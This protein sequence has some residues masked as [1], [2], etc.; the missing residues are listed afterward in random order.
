VTCN[1]DAIG[2]RLKL[3]AGGRDQHLVLNGG[4][5][6]GNLPLEQ[7]FGLGRARKAERLEVWWPGGERETFDDLTANQTIAI[8]QGQGSY[9]VVKRGPEPL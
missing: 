1:R 9:T 8:S 3:T 5:N 4:S 2:A 7:H 6:F